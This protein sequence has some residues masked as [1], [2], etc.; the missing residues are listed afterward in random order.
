MSQ[1]IICA[2]KNGMTIYRRNSSFVAVFKAFFGVFGCRISIELKTA[3]PAA[4]HLSK[5]SIVWV[6]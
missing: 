2:L 5:V 1:T 6:E 3:I 4:F